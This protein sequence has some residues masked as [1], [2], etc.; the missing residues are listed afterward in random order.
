MSQKRAF[1]A[2][3]YL[4]EC[5]YH[6]EEAQS[7]SNLDFILVLFHY[8]CKKEHRIVLKSVLD[9]VREQHCLKNIQTWSFFGA[10]FPVFSSYAQRYGKIQ[11]LNAVEV[12]R[13]CILLV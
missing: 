9:G 7:M 12:L 8:T 6:V 2:N 10:Y 3:F 1:V 13:L 11:T 4:E 5:K